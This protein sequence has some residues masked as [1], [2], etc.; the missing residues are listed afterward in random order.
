MLAIGANA[1]GIRRQIAYKVVLVSDEAPQ[2]WVEFTND[3]VDVQQHGVGRARA[4]EIQDLARQEGSLGGG[5]NDF[6]Q[7]S[8]QRVV[9]AYAPGR[10]AAG[11]E[12]ARGQGVAAGGAP[13]GKR[14]R[15]PPT[16]A[17]PEPP[18]ASAVPFFSLPRRERDRAPV[19]RGGAALRP[20]LHPALSVLLADPCEPGKAGPAT[21]ANA[22]RAATLPRGILPPLAGGGRYPG[23]SSTH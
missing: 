22:W 11:E 7:K 13:G 18:A 15:P 8:A 2:K 16:P 20:S 9:G 14:R 17:R 10:S 4:A 6:F 1:R 21:E 12:D 3:S 5:P 23:Y 19:L